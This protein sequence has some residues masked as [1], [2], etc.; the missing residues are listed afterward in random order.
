MG[1]TWFAIGACLGV[2]SVAAALATAGRVAPT[3]VPGA[4]VR[5]TASPTGALDVSPKGS[6]LVAD[7]MRPGSPAVR[8][9]LEV[10]N[11]TAG[12]VR[13]QIAGGGGDTG[14]GTDELGDGLIV[15]V[16]DGDELIAS[17]PLA[18]LRTAP[19]S[20]T[21]PLASGQSRSLVVAAR[22]DPTARDHQGALVEVPLSVTAVPIDG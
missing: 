4:T 8:G 9:T 15:E 22:L 13:L 6:F 17:G 20:A 7:D 3:D 18:R 16:R 10:F 19:A 14:T 11:Q 2:I 1:R 5:I 21:S 12:P